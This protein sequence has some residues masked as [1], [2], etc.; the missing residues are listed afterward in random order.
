MSQTRADAAGLAKGKLAERCDATSYE[1]HNRPAL[2]SCWERMHCRVHTCDCEHLPKDWGSHARDPLPPAGQAL[3]WGR[4]EMW[5]T[6]LSA[7]ML[8]HMLRHMLWHMRT[9]QRSPGSRMPRA[10]TACRGALPGSQTTTS[11]DMY[12]VAVWDR[13]GTRVPTH[14]PHPPCKCSAGCRTA[15]PC[16]GLQAACEHDPDVP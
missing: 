13:L 8:R 5:H 9:H 14:M 6:F 12:V 3:R 1:A 7:N 10:S 15:G 4:R 2:V 16:D 11:N